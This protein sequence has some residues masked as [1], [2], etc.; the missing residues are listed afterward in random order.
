MKNE[1]ALQVLKEVL[2]AATKSGV[3]P[4]MDASFTAANAFNI[5][6]NVIKEI[7]PDAE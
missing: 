4:N 6:A 7:K 2:D 1:Q 5:I 3:F